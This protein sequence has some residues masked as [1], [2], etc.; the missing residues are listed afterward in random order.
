MTTRLRSAPAQPAPG[1]TVAARATRTLWLTAVLLPLVLGLAAKAPELVLPIGPDQGTYSYVAERILAGGQPYVD[2][3]DNKPPATYFVHAAVLALVPAAVRWDRSCFPG[4]LF[5][6]CGY[7]ALQVTD[8]AWTAATVLVLYA[9]A[10]RL[11][12]NSR[13]AVVAACIAAVFMNLSQLSKEG[14]TPEKE[15]LLPMVIA[16]LA[17]LRWCEGRQP[18]WLV[19]AGG[20][21]GV[22]FLFKQ[23]ALAI[24]LALATWALW[25][26]SNQWPGRK[27]W[28]RP[29][30]TSLTLFALGWAM[31]VGVACGYLALRGALGAFWQAAFAYNIA[32]AGSDSSVTTLPYAF[33]RG[34]WQVFNESSAL[35]WLLAFGGALRVVANRQP[36]ARLAL[37]WAVADVLSL[38]LG[39]TKF[40]QVYFVQLVPAFAILAAMALDALWAATR[41]V[42]VARLYAG[43]ALAT[44]FALSTP[45]QVHV[46][47]RAWNERM[48]GRAVSPA[49]AVVAQ[50]LAPLGGPLF[51]WGDASQAYLLAGAWSPSRFFQV[52][53]VSQFFTRG[54]GYLERR[55][56]LL[57]DLERD[58]PAAIAIDPGTAR[59]DP[60]GTRDLNVTSFPELQRLIATDYQPVADLPDG[61]LAYARTYARR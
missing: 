38:F 28:A 50:Q 20:A 52:Y 54:P 45:L 57:R 44:V 14:S 51:I 7:V 49:E 1:A 19:L 60:D 30:S 59:S 31:P 33:L 16:Y 48:P 4:G 11:C 10:R 58:P 37:C 3:F 25:T 29:S 6:P 56:E 34:T 27:G 21:A 36:I 2:A 26:A 12:G 40:A 5:Q 43:V 9:V 24:P 39:G 22:A 17:V 55:A 18:G 61:W 41:G 15:L 53:P 47:L 35:L 23:T 32:Q 13:I 42:P 8:I 46:S